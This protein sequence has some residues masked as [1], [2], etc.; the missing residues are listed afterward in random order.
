MII[1]LAGFVNY[2]WHLTLLP[3]TPVPA[4]SGNKVSRERNQIADGIESALLD[5][6]Y[7]HQVFLALEWAIPRPEI[8][9]GPGCGGSDPW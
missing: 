3:V 1:N 4:R 5:A 9:D 6:R 2:D 7:L 8:E